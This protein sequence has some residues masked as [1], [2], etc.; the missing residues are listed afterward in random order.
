MD[1]PSLLNSEART[2]G[3]APWDF[4]LKLFDFGQK[5]FLH[6]SVLHDVEASHL[7]RQRHF[8]PQV[9]RL[10]MSSKRLLVE[11]V[12]LSSTRLSWFTNLAEGLGVPMAPWHGATWQKPDITL[13]GDPGLATG[14]LL[15]LVNASNCARVI[16][17]TRGT[18]RLGLTCISDPL[19]AASLA[20]ALTQ[21]GL[22]PRAAT[23]QWPPVPL[24]LPSQLG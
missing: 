5:A 17:W 1:N 4:S 18:S 7:C 20:V 13:L 16:L 9:W 11:P 21:I 10:S 14:R 19:S 2:I 15:E 3:V 22:K 12:N 24:T 23:P 8:G 6:C